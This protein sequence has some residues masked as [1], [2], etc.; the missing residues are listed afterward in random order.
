MSVPAN[1]LDDF[2]TLYPP[3][4][5]SSSPLLSNS[6]SHSS[7]NSEAELEKS[8]QSSKE[9]KRCLL[10]TIP[11]TDRE[12]HLR[13]LVGVDVDLES[14][15]RAAEITRPA[16]AGERNEHEPTED[17]LAEA[18]EGKYHVER[19]RWEE[20]RIELYQGAVETYSESL[21]SGIEAMFAT[22]VR[23]FKNRGLKNRTK[24]HF[25]QR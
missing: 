18:K 2:P 7:S 24:Y 17:E 12:L 21:A 8:A 25:L 10:N 20:L 14:L 6:G 19:E 1:H 4:P 11:R 3:S 5:G 9:R 23:F 16:R 13:R 22:E 15:G